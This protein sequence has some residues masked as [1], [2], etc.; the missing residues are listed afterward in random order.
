MSEHLSIN[1]ILPLV[2]I[3]SPV[4]PSHAP[5]QLTMQLLYLLY[6]PLSTVLCCYLHYC[7]LSLQQHLPHLVLPSSPDVPA[8]VQLLLCQVILAQQVIELIHGQA[9]QGLLG[10]KH[11]LRSK[12]W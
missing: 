10:N 1:I 11:R 6:L 3:P 8:D 4:S 12:Y 5:G 2:L 9:N 7:Q